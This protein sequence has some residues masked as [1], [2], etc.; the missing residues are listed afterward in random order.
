MSRFDSHAA[1]G[2]NEQV[3]TWEKIDRTGF[4][5]GLVSAAL[6][7]AL[8]TVDPIASICQTDAAFDRGSIF[9]H[10]TLAALGESVLVFIHVDELEDGSAAVA[11]TTHP[12]AQLGSL[13]VMEVWSDPA[14]HAELM[15]LTLTLD[16]G[17]MRRSEIEPAHCED[18]HC[19]AD[20]GYS[21]TSFPDDLT[22]RVSRAAD[23]ENE[24]EAAYAF[25]QALSQ[26]LGNARE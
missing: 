9:R 24:L 5:P 12:L 15:E 22:I 18:P 16:L 26:R 2:H 21:A 11:T 4:Y 8:G 19:T 10:L 7:R 23:G 20:H 25:A 3:N 1:C 14:H 6:R 17:A 13:A